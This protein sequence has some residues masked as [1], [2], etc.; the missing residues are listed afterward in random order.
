MNRRQQRKTENEQPLLP[1]LASVQSPLRKTNRRKQWKRMDASNSFNKLSVRSV[2]SCSISPRSRRLLTSAAP[3]YT[4]PMARF[5]SAAP[6]P[7][8]GLAI[9]TA[10]RLFSSPSQVHE[11]QTAELTSSLLAQG[12][13]ALLAM[14]LSG[15]YEW[16]SRS[17]PIS[18]RNRS[19]SIS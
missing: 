17:T 16:F 12:C 8:R 4:P 6:P 11:V 9:L 18:R 19:G 15:G 5:F 13:N 1:L 10:Q 7:T 14:A 3:I 2:P